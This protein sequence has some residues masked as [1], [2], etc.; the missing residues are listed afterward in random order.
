MNR[1]R[2]SVVSTFVDELDC[3]EASTKTA[4]DAK[5]NNLLCYLEKG[6]D[7][8]AI[9]KIGKFRFSSFQNN[10]VCFSRI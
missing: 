4:L 5:L 3:A 10:T 1:R 9:E 7:L 8:K 6:A 2:Y